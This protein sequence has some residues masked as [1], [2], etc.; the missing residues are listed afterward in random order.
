[1]KTLEFVM[2]FTSALPDSIMTQPYKKPKNMLISANLKA[3]VISALRQTNTA[4]R[5]LAKSG[6]N[7]NLTN[8]TKFEPIF[9]PNI[10]HQKKDEVKKMMS[11]ISKTTRSPEETYWKFERVI[12]LTKLFPLFPVFRKANYN[13]PTIY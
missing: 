7:D 1:M 2:L 4:Q 11:D 13:Q 8:G 5:I 3:K 12:N 9:D 10:G 6:I